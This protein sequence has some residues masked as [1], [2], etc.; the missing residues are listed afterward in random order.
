[1][2]KTP[3]TSTDLLTTPMLAR[4]HGLSEPFLRR[5]VRAG[6]LRTIKLGFR[7]VRRADF[8]AW[9]DKHAAEGTARAAKAG[10]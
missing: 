9:L 5:E 7:R 10:K 2:A 3:E 4:V 6:R 1:M 8:D